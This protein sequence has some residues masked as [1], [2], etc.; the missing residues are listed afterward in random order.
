MEACFILFESKVLNT[1]AVCFN[2]D[3][4]RNKFHVTNA[5]KLSFYTMYSTHILHYKHLLFGG[6]K[7]AAP[8]NARQGQNLQLLLSKWLWYIQ[9][10]LILKQF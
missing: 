7:R 4:L 5:K 3:T 10:W 1:R 8:I 6:N 9:Q 2:T